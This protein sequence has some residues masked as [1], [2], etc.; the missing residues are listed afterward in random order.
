MLTETAAP[1]F[2]AAIQEETARHLRLSD[3]FVADQGAEVETAWR[4]ALGHIERRL[5]LCL[6][7]RA[8]VYRASIQE[9]CIVHPPTAPIRALTSAGVVLSDG[10]VDAFDVAELTVEVGPLRA[11][12]RLPFLVDVIEIAFE[13]GFGDSWDDTPAELRQAVQMLAAHMFDQ[14]HALGGETQVSPHGVEALI[15]P[16][17]PVRLTARAG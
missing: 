17:A 7:P 2:T 13:A 15:R 8:F 3:E 11:G 14:R 16:W 5:G 4:A 1:A 9:R 12:V 6:S 10:T